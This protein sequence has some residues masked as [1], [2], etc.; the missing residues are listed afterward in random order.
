LQKL[1]QHTLEPHLPA[2]LFYNLLLTAQ[3]P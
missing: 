3:R 2:A 1:D